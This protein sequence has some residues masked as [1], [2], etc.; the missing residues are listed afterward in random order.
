MKVVDASVLIAWLDADDSHHDRAVA[1][2]EECADEPLAASV[3]TLA[4][5]MV[6]P[7]RAGRLAEVG[8]AIERLGVRSVAVPPDAA[9]ELASLRTVTNLRMPDCCVILAGRMVEGQ[10]LTFDGR[11]AD[12]ARLLNE[13]V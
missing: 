2:L 12:C 11:L 5:T 3:V 4:E 6:G 13:P 1:V 7:A 8:L 9:A 10:V